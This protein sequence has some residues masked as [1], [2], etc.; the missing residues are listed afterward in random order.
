MQP[1][2]SAVLVAS[3]SL[4]ISMSAGPAG[5]EATSEAPA[6][7]PLVQ[8]QDNPA[9]PPNI[10][11][12][13]LDDQRATGTLDVMPNVR[14]FFQ[15]DG[16]EFTQSMVATPLC[17]PS[18]ASTFTG[19]YPHNHGVTGNGLDAEVAALDQAATI[20][21]YLQ[22]GG[23]QTALAGKY[24]NTVPLARSP[25]HWDRWTFTTGGYV[26][27]YY[28]QDGTVRRV[29]GYYTDVLGDSVSEYLEDFE[30]EDD[31]PWFIY[32]SP[33]A[34]H[35][36]LTPEA[37]YAAA[38]TPEWVQPASFNE[39]D[40]SDKPS[41][42]RWRDLLDEAE[43]EAF[44]DGQLRTIMSVDDLVGRVVDEMDRLGETA[45]TLAIYTSDNGHHWG[46]HRLLTKRFPYTESVSVPFLMRW[47]GVVPAG[48]T[49]TRLVSNVDVLPT[50]LQASGVSPELV[51]PLDGTSLLSPGRRSE[52]L[53]EYGRSLDSTLPPWAS[54]RTDTEQFVE[55]YSAD[56]GAL[57]E[58]EFYDL[59][60]DPLQLVNTLR[61]GNTA[62]DPDVESWSQRL[63]EARACVGEDCLVLGEPPVLE[64]PVAVVGEPVCSG[65]SCVFDGSG[66]ADPDGGALASF[67]WDFGD[68]EQGSGVSVTH[69]F[70]AAGS[71]EVTLTVTDD[72]GET[73]SVSRT[74]SVTDLVAELSYRGGDSG[75]S[76]TWGEA[77]TVSVPDGVRGGDVLV[78]F[79]SANKD[80]VSVGPP[81]GEVSGWT[82]VGSVVDQTL[83]TVLWVAVAGDGQAG[84]DVR[85][86]SSGSA[87][88]DVHL[89][90]YAGVDANDPV[91]AFAGEPETRW[92]RADHITPVVQASGGEWALSFWADMTS[93]TT[94]WEVP[95][96]LTQRVLSVHDL[97][98]YR[99]TSVSADSNGAVSAGPVGGQTAVASSANGKATMWTVLLR[100]GSG[101]PPVLEPPVAVVGE[102]V[103][104]GLSCVFD[105]SG[106]ADPDGGALASFEWDFGDGEQGS[107]VSVT[108]VFGAAGSFEV[109]LTVTDDEGETGS[110][111]RTVSVSEPV[112]EPPVAVVGEPV[113]SGL[114]CVFDGS[115]SADPDGGA[116]ASFEWDFGD[117]EQG[118][119][120]SVTHVFGAAGSFEVTLTVT[121]D[122]GETG[123]VSRTVSVTDLVAELSYRGGDSGG[124]STWGEAVT[125]SVPDGVRGGDVLVLFTSANKDSVSVGPPQGEVSGW[126][127]VGSVVDQTLQTVLWVAVAG[128][129]QA[130]GDVRVVSSG[131]AK[132]DVHLLAYAG[133]DANDPVAAFAGEP[134]TRWGRA[135][136]ITPVVQA[137]GGEWAL[138]FW[139]D[140]TSATT[141]WEVPAELTQRVLSVHDLSS[142]RVTSVSADSNGA[143]SA[144]P[145]GGQTAVASSANGKATMWTVLLRPGSGEPPVLEPPVAVVGE[146][147]CSGLSCVF[148]GSGSADP[149][150]GALASF[151][152][153]FGDGE[154]G[155][156]V[157]V[158]HVFGA[159]GSFEVTLT[160]TD[161]EGETGSVS[162][163]V[164]V[165]EPSAGAVDTAEAAG[166]FTVE[167]SWESEP[168]DYDNDGDDD[169]WIGYHDQGGALL[170]NDGNGAY[171]R[172]AE[173]AFP[174]VN[175]A[176]RIPD[177]HDCA[178]ADVD[179]NGLPDAYCT[180]GRGTNNPVKV[181]R[182]NELWLQQGVGE[183]VEV[184]HDWAVGELCGRS[185]YAAFFDANGD[186]FPDLFVGNVPPRDDPDDPCDDPAAGLPNEEAKLY[187]NEG[188]SALVYDQT[189]GIGGYGGERCAEVSDVNGDGRDDLLLCGN[190]GTQLYVNTGQSSFT[191]V[192]A[193][194]GLSTKFSDAVF[195]DMDGD[196]DPDLVGSIWGR[197]EL[198]LNNSGTFGPAQVIASVPAGGGGRSVA[199]GDADGDGDLD[200][201]GLVANGPEDTNPDD[202]LL[203]NDGLS[204][205]PV[206]VPPAA[207]VGD[208]ATALDGDADGKHEF[209]VLNGLKGPGP[210]QLIEFH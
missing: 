127:R 189:M 166:L 192:A 79:T 206:G 86:V 187:L 57:T 6:S 7:P 55:W 89:L 65:L 60:N 128:D 49:D 77:V 93:A 87:K 17:T 181:D 4:L 64:P 76:S 132:L 123:S 124:S 75:G 63:A 193:E 40:I 160:V 96:E 151:E 188:G 22:A 94:D 73:G 131:S 173:D 145:V 100:P 59:A 139:A 74:V 135:D 190:P 142:Y 80:S 164:S 152:W 36:P 134:E 108:H 122:E 70:G 121:D 191:E 19:R 35:T 66:S 81:Q 48:A 24:L 126:T 20:Q 112:L 116:L 172:V 147:V 13:N 84:G 162:R 43:V 88:L 185:H 150:G 153:D 149:D 25:L 140:M 102:P 176:G 14:S 141:D 33:Q 155:S 186:D 198:Y 83:Q 158:T 133:V 91:A 199:V 45:N 32:I 101:E 174:R 184:G 92:G 42:V 61:D 136:H 15:D 31:E 56:A 99:V 129:G 125:V 58:R 209:L 138:S 103:C 163:T 11:V 157:S 195:G 69:V 208:G 156:G 115:G 130:G 9:Q 3:V 110:V 194:R 165:T 200:V 52:L 97:S 183:F 82:R 44:R 95:A 68:G 27:V 30:Q 62:N 18:R 171:T 10:L 159:A 72:E 104:S 53:L 161:D 78:L 119:G 46:E 170:Q 23:Y 182:E 47:P 144:G 16:T 146:P 67:E 154:Q 167:E 111:S 207:G 118:S 180:A 2:K 26:D 148:D 29:P 143:V 105:G 71:F 114:S 106:S 1:R 175:A 85:V 201:Y 28:N 37:K 203:I 204:F 12:F 41:N 113:C 177:R 196:G 38:P 210:I 8:M 197:F 50:A 117:G 5:A 54:I 39:A 179:A 178:W 202:M 21:G 107:G 109:T 169:V 98:S 34:P 205:T 137:S 168:V 51:Y 120:V 90:A